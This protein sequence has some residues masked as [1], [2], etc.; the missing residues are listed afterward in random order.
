MLGSI[1][2]GWHPIGYV[3]W[4]DYC[5]RVIAARIKDGILPDAP[6]FGNIKTFISDWYAASYQGLVDVIT[7]GFPCQPFSVAGK[8][9]GA[10]DERNMW[11]ATA[12]CIGIVR[13]R[14][15]LLE[16]VPGIRSYLPVVVRDLRRCGYEVRHP[17]Q[18]GA[19][20]VGAPHRRKRVWIVA[21]A[22][23]VGSGSRRP[24]CAGQQGRIALVRPGDVADT[25][26]ITE[27]TGLCQ[28]EPG[29]LR[30]GR[31]GNGSSEELSNTE[32]AVLE[33]QDTK[34]NTCTNGR[35]LQFIRRDWWA[36]ESDV[37]R[38]AHGVAHRVD[39]LKAIGNGQV[40]RVV[41]SAWHMLM[42]T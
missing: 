20:D 12:E 31:S 29:R 3:E 5:Q 4:D 11:P 33:G 14:F 1:L 16:N 6:I 39:R 22:G 41:A 9:K 38:V 40:P 25:E 23:G 17:L 28:N 10:D 7:G 30:R 2:L 32:T 37:G 8:Q 36:T 26:G 24:E 13:P 21:N 18:L 35:A 15:V 34:G 27:R 42:E 19:D